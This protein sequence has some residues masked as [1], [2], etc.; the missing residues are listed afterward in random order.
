MTIKIFNKKAKIWQGKWQKISKKIAVAS[1]KL[2]K[3]HPKNIKNTG[4][5]TSEE[6]VRGTQMLFVEQRF[7]M[8]GWLTL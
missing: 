7:L 4:K 1:K 6:G 3:I 8:I 5:K 2:A